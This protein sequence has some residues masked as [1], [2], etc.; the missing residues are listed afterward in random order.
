MI[1]QN[2]SI[3]HSK[4]G[5]IVLLSVYR[6]TGS[7]IARG[8]GATALLQK[9]CP[10]CPQMKLH[11]VQRSME[12]YICNLSLFMSEFPMDW[13]A[14]KVTP[15]HKSGDK[16][17]V[18][19]YRPI[20]VLSIVSKIMERAVHNQLYEYLMLRNSLN[21]CQSGFRKNHSTVTKL[22][23]VQD[24]ILNNTDKGYVTAALFLDL[25]NVLILER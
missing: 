20:S 2:E 6:P 16:T 14:A 21:V 19:N 22:L 11:F 12:A 17:N 4:L 23:D 10:S 15:I 9:L 8:Q 3:I 18:D 5:N 13:K 7:G 1:K 24:F 25:K